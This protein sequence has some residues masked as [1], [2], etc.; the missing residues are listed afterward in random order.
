MDFN[1]NRFL[2][3]QEYE[4]DVALN[5]IRSGRK[6]GH[7]MWYIFPQLRGLGQ[8]GRAQFFGIS[9]PDEARAYLAD[10][11]LG[12]RLTE[13]SQALLALEDRNAARIFGYPDV[14]KLRSCMTLFASV[15][16]PDS[17]FHRVLD[18]FFGG[19]PDETTLRLL[20]DTQ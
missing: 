4:Y 5:E 11:L 16:E 7:W 13:I 6:V 14:L 12:A 8:S 18:A 19:A 10:P 20:Q 15:S 17:V 1:L 9:G 2:H 3:A